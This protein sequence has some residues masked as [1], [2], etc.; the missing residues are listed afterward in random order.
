LII[1]FKLINK[2]INLINMSRI[3]KVSFNHESI[4]SIEHMDYFIIRLL[5][6][7][8]RFL[9][10][11]KIQGNIS[12]NFND[13]LFTGTIHEDHEN[14]LYD[15][16]Y[17]DINTLLKQQKVFN[18][19]IEHLED[20]LAGYR[21]SPRLIVRRFGCKKIINYNSPI[22]KSY[23]ATINAILNKYN[24]GH[25]S[26]F[27]SGNTIKY[28]INTGYTAYENYLLKIINVIE[29]IIVNN[30]DILR[31][32]KNNKSGNNTINELLQINKDLNCKIYELNEQFQ[33][34]AT[35]LDNM[36]QFIKHHYPIGYHAHSYNTGFVNLMKS[37]GGM[38]PFHQLSER[39][40]DTQNFNQYGSHSYNTYNDIHDFIRKSPLEEGEL[41]ENSSK[42]IKLNQPGEDYIPFF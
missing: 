8:N 29:N 32:I 17:K 33:Y 28:T 9:K 38:E 10:D 27:K 36:Q 1:N 7:L 39:Q 34:Y 40:I 19:L 6:E 11:H 4:Y 26:Y 37:P 24:A 41:L 5:N 30:S 31:K 22:I 35:T 2:D 18:Q 23:F 14:V 16:I 21:R 13:K 25:A 20:H 12:Y 15:Y 3:K 42:R